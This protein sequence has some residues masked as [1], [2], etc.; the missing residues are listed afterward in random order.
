MLALVSHQGVPPEHWLVSVA[1]HSTQAPL[2]QAGYGAWALQS[3]FAEQAPHTWPAHTGE[4]VGQSDAAA[5]ATHSPTDVSQT[6]VAPVHAAS[7][8]AEHC[9]QRPSA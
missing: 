9:P 6:A 4:V 2:T 5:H 7:F 1:E 3:E 8:D